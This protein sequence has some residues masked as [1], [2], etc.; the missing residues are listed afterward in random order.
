MYNLSFDLAE[1]LKSIAAIEVEPASSLVFE[2]E[3]L[4]GEDIKNTQTMFDMTWGEFYNNQGD[5]PKEQPKGDNIIWYCP[6]EKVAHI[7]LTKLHETSQLI[8]VIDL[9]ISSPPDIVVHLYLFA[10]EIS[11]YDVTLRT[12]MIRSPAC[13]HTHLLMCAPNRWDA[14]LFFLWAC[15]DVLE[16]IPFD[17]CG[18][19][20]GYNI[21]TDLYTESSLQRDLNNNMGKLVEDK[22]YQLAIDRKLLLPEEVVALKKGKY[23]I[24]TDINQRIIE[25]N[26]I[27]IRDLVCNHEN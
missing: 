19:V 16:P 18:L 8:T 24:L 12:A 11:D 26:Q 9:L 17:I 5:A 20:E 2:T 10:S 21:L 14:N 15:G 4:K 22:K 3:D 23:L 13:I 7:Y 25:A 6:E 1:G 27:S